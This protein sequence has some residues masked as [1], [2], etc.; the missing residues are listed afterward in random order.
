[1]KIRDLSV[2]KKF[3]IFFGLIVLLYLIGQIYPLVSTL[4]IKNNIEKLNEKAI[5]LL[6]ESKFIVENAIFAKINSQEYVTSITPRV[7]FNQLEEVYHTKDKINASATNFTQIVSSFE[8]I[9]PLIENSED[10]LN[11]YNAI[12]GQLQKYQTVFRDYGQLT[13]DLKDFEGKMAEPKS[14]FVSNLEEIRKNCLKHNDAQAVMTI[15]QIIHSVDRANAL[16]EAK[17]LEFVS[18]QAK[19]DMAFLKQYAIK[20][21][22][23]NN[24]NIVNKSFDDFITINKEFSLRAP[25]YKELLTQSY[26]EGNKF[27]ELI[28]EFYSKI[29]NHTSSLSDS[30][31]QNASNNISVLMVV[32]IVIAI[33]GILILRTIAV[34]VVN[35]FKRTNEGLEKFA[36][37]DLVSRMPVLG[38]D[39]QGQQA[40]LIN[41]MAD[42]FTTVVKNIK[43]IAANIASSSEQILANAQTTSQGANTQASS[44]EEVSSSIEEM[45]AG[46]QQNSTNAQ[47]TEQIAQR[48]LDNI[49]ESSQITNQAV[50]AMRDIASKISIIDEIAFQTNI[51]ALNAAVEAARAGEHGKGFA[52]VASEVRKLAERSAEA[53]SEIDVVSKEGVEISERAGELLS[54]IIPEVEKTTELVK[55]ISTACME[56]SSGIEQINNAV[57]Q[58]NRITQEYASASEEMSSASDNLTRQSEELVKSVEFFKV[59]NQNTSKKVFASK[60]IEKPIESKIKSKEVY[61]P[62]ASKPQ[63]DKGTIINLLD[64]FEAKDNFDK[65]YEKF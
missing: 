25:K 49:K 11:D 26:S 21:D 33:V 18:E 42:K 34:N 16:Q 32:T 44:A 64:G 57:Q 30:V 62:R 36:S 4:S 38:K 22:C 15:S 35:D 47:Q 50:V 58:L 51:L 13:R 9:K 28:D 56:Q 60:T 59:D 55:E 27:L 29:V 39:E 8:K 61:T 45:S 53:A 65:D 3:T 63:T 24:Y 54:S 37:G 14:I 52:V 40:E 19:K 20:Y 1:M 17:T 6:S 23:V 48:A 41:K 46:I 5:P 7:L 12:L 10:L 43:T 31:G 2:V